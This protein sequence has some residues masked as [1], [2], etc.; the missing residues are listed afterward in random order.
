MY[1]TADQAICL[2]GCTRGQLKYW[3]ETGLVTPEELREDASRRCRYSYTFQN[4]VELRA[5][6]H[7]LDKG[8]TLQKIRRTIAFLK[9]NLGLERPLAESKLI[10]DGSTIFKL[11]A[12]SGEIV[13]TL[14]EGQIAFIIAL[15]NIAREIEQF[16]TELMR[17]RQR[18]IDCLTGEEHY[19][20]QEETQPA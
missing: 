13:D 3:R 16:R 20:L 17:E 1:F 2:T 12:T 4:L 15:D 19:S 6:K 11:C 8:I 18:F 7:M 14:K 5:V 9:E 10:T